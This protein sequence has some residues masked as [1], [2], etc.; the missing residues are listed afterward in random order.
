MLCIK[1]V[2]KL[3][4]LISIYEVGQIHNIIKRKISEVLQF[5]RLSV[6]SIALDYS[7]WVEVGHKF[8]NLFRDGNRVIVCSESSVNR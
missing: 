7:L 6:S 3:T 2:L 1:V 5:R 4:T 8:L